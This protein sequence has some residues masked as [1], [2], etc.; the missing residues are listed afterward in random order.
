MY[1]QYRANFCPGSIDHRECET[2]Y[3]IFVKEKGSLEDG[4]GFSFWLVTGGI[5]LPLW[6]NPAHTLRHEPRKGDL[7]I[8]YIPNREFQLSRGRNKSNHF[9]YIHVR[10]KETD[11]GEVRTCSLSI[12]YP[13]Y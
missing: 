4:G 7:S 9:V 1:D 8:I 2:Y 11:Q 10:A 6:K 13:G 12:Y 3:R 5:S